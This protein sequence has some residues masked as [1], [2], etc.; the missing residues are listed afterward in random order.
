[1]KKIYLKG[2]YKKEV[3]EAKLSNDA[4]Q[5]ATFLVNR[6]GVQKG[7]RREARRAIYKA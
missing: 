5:V 2:Q 1:M 3:Q 6:Y 4:R 7:Q